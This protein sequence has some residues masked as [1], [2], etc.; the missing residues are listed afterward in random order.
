MGRTVYQDHEPA[1]M[2]GLIA[3]LVHP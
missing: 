1:E 2:A 3:A